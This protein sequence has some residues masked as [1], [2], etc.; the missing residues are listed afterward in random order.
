MKHLIVLRRGFNSLIDP[1]ETLMQ[2]K[3]IWEKSPA[4]LG[5]KSGEWR[6]RVSADFPLTDLYTLYKHKEPVKNFNDWPKLWE[7]VSVPQDQKPE[8]PK[9]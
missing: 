9:I 6:V 3:M 2:K 7:I 4:Y 1:L 5:Y 8:P